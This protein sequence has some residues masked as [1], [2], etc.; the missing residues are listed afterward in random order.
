MATKTI[1]GHLTAYDGTTTLYAL[2]FT[3][4]GSAPLNG[5]GDAL[6]FGD[7]NT[8]TFSWTETLSA[9]GNFDVQLFKDSDDTEYTARYKVWVP[10]DN[11]GTYDIGSFDQLNTGAF[12]KQVF[13]IIIRS[14]DDTNA[15]RFYYPTANATFSTKTVSINGGTAVNITGAVTYIGTVGA[16]YEY[17]LAYN[18]ADRPTAEGTASYLF[19]DG[20]NPRRVNL[21]TLTIAGLTTE[22]A[23]KLELLGTPQAAFQTPV[24]QF[25]YIEQIIR[26]DD[27]TAANGRAF[28]WTWTPASGYVLATSTCKFGGISACD[29]TTV[30][31]SI[32]GTITS[33]DGVW[34]LS[35]DMGKA[36]TAAIADAQYNWSVEVTNAAGLETT[37][38]KSKPTQPVQIV[39]KQT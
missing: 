2:V 35:F 29:G 10:G 38:R 17:Q 39:D 31:W 11:A 34:T 23:A 20:T 33:T 32:S 14:V 8:F 6:T 4:N 27:Y 26:G 5:D 1:R 7:Y 30:G 24:T 21:Q 18:A 36:I 37:V 28:E 12:A 22:Q 3:E 15:I 19:S 25:G 16:F 9:G 13:P